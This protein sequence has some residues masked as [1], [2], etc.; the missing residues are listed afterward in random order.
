MK[1]AYRIP[2]GSRIFAAL[3]AATRNEEILGLSLYA[4]V[5]ARS[6]AVS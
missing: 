5:C 6:D 4:G 1:I 2:L 3:A